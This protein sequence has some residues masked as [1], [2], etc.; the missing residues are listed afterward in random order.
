MEKTIIAN[1]YRRLRI[2]DDSSVANPVDGDPVKQTDSLNN[3]GRNGTRSPQQLEDHI[4]EY[5]NERD[6]DDIP[7]CVYGDV[8]G[9][10]HLRRAA[11]PFY[12]N[13]PLSA[14]LSDVL[15]KQVF[16]VGVGKA[17]SF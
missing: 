3:H 16:Y 13:N 7:Q 2:A 11:F 4:H 5:K 1:P 15:R 9:E 17:R 6:V 10:L 8:V 12:K 14:N